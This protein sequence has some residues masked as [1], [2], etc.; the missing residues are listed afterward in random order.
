MSTDEKEERKRF[1]RDELESSQESLPKFNQVLEDNKSFLFSNGEAEEATANGVSEH[2]ESRDG[3]DDNVV[4]QNVS[5]LRNIVPDISLEMAIGLCKQYAHSGDVISS[6]IGH[7]FEE[8]SKAGN[9]SSPSRKSLPESLTTPIFEI[10]Q[11]SV[12]PE[13]AEKNTRYPSPKRLKPSV[14]WKRFI[15]SLQ[16]NVM[17]TRPTLKPLK[18][19]SELSIAKPAGEVKLSKLYDASGHKKSAFAAYV[20]VFDA[21]HNREL[22]RIPENIAQILYPLMNI[23]DFF[24]EA[25]MV[26]CDNKRLSIGDSFIV[27]LDCFITSALFNPTTSS[28]HNTSFA[29]NSRA[30]TWEGSQTIVE[31]QEELEHRSRR[32]SLLALFDR[33]RIAPYTE[34]KERGVGETEIIDLESEGSWSEAR[35]DGTIKQGQETNH[36]DETLNLNQLKLFYNATQS[37]EAL[38]KL[39]EYEPSNDVFKLNLRRYQKQG[40]AWMLKREHAYDKLSASSEVEGVNENTMNPLWKQFEW[41]RDMSWAAQRSKKSQERE[42]S[43]NERFFYANLHTGEFSMD[44]PVL[45]TMT[46]G[47]ILSDEMGLGKTISALSLILSAPFDAKYL[48]NKSGMFEEASRDSSRKPYAAKTTL[49]VVPMSLLTQWGSEFERAN[50]AA[51]FYC[52]VYYGGNVSSLKTLLTKTKNPP[53]VVLTTYGIVQSEWSKI[54]KGKSLHQNEGT[55]GLFSIDFYRIIIDEGHTIRNRMTATSKAVLQLSSKCRWVLTGTPIINRLDD[56]YSLVKFLRLEPWSQIGYWKLFVSEP[57]E[58]KQFK[59]AF[60]LVNA[61]LGPVSLRR[62]KEMRDADG[63]KLVELP[64]KEVIVEK[65]QFNT[66]QEKIYKYFLDK[67]ENSVKT[68]LA[69]GDLLKK[70]STILVHILRLRQICCDAALLGSQDENDEDLR[71]GAQQFNE[72]VNVESILGNSEDSSQPK[73]DGDI[74]DVIT[75]VAEKYRSKDSFESLEC[76]ICTTESINLKS[77]V[78]LECGHAFCQPCIED[79]LDFQKQKKLE[80]RCPNCRELF[81]TKF[82]LTLCQD[83]EGNF[84]F[85]PYNE[86]SKPAKIL[87]L[88]KHLKLLQ[89][90]AAGEQVVVFSQFSSYLDILERELS[91]AF[92]PNVAKIYKFDGRLNLKERSSVLQEFSVKD[93]SRQKILLLSLKAGGVGLNLTCASHAFMMDPWWSPSMEDQAIDRIHRIGQT[94]NVKVI[95]LIMENSIEEKMLHIQERKRTIGEAVDADEDERRKRRIEEIKMLFE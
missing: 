44:R 32:T 42:F 80:M 33:L 58:R 62:T 12:S 21:Q 16:M 38:E 85:V 24:F 28:F 55:S 34:E 14:S 75:Q 87:A 37:V 54:G 94:N 48:A 65:I 68:G 66:S 76:S 22:G 13:P 83:S 73:D 72:S 2:V 10:S 95:R 29:K 78:F 4:S 5:K 93:L 60:D 41:P 52:E 31:T 82:L 90:T 6:A 19:G 89:D 40:L 17:A 84:T 61:I 74:S 49:I 45:K 81:R 11:Q 25:T 27:Q 26:F 91:N 30:R 39:P 92:P 8:A 59:Q 15:G 47:G 43:S 88:L 1:F 77:A 46:K 36:Q 23:D 56:L 70:Y 9:L 3:N 20:K 57:F 71:D 67:A 18:Y 50:N 51:D 79:Y 7:Y 53:T 35:K 63:K 69:H 86:S 64:P